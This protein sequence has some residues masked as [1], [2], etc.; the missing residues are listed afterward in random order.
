[1]T[2]TNWTEAAT[3]NKY[4]GTNAW[5]T[6]GGDFTTI[7]RT[8]H[9]C[10]SRGNWTTFASETWSSAQLI[11]DCYDNQSKNV[12]LAMTAE[13]VNARDLVFYSRENTNTTNRPKLTVTYTVLA[14]A[15]FFPFF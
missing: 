3:W 4:D 6:A 13:E 2:R 12:H 1:M 15:N 11:Q 9:S 5:T 14:P 10:P 8:S 7:N